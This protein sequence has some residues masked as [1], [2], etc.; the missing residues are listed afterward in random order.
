L[1][2]LR[3][4]VELGQSGSKVEVVARVVGQVESS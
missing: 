3:P 4:K 2:R 1:S